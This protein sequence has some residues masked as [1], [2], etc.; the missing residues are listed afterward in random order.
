V[1][2]TAESAVESAWK[3]GLAPDPILTVDDWANRHRML[4]SV[5]S[6]EPGRWSTSRTPYLAE[7]MASL[8]ATSRFERVVFMA[9]GQVGKTECGLN[10]VG[11]VIHHAP[12]PMLL[13]QPTVEGAKRVSKQRVDALIEA[14]PELASRVKDPRSRDS[15]NTQL[16][17]EFPGGVLIMTGANSAVGLRSMPVRYLFLD[18]VDGYPGDA[19]GEGDPVALAVQRAATFVN[20]KVYLCSTPT[21]KGF[22]RIEAAYLES[23][24]RVFEVP[25]D[26]CGVRSQIQWRDI[27]WPTGKMADAA[28]HCPACDGIHPE[29]RKPALLANG[30]GTSRAE[31]DG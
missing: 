10:W 21:L 29:Y 7:V 27:K 4:S 24:Q 17:K 11:Y 20:R 25:C 22:S 8:S 16:M 18:E 28:W 12:G 5:A 1:F 2:D 14:S 30:R 31:G 3:R 13:V 19:D 9:G 15:G 23:D 26:H 6:A